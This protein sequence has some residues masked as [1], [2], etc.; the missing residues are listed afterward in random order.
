MDAHELD[1]VANML[2][3]GAFDTASY[4]SHFTDTHGQPPTI[5]SK[6]HHLRSAVQAAV[7]HSGRYT[8]DPNYAEF[9]RVQIFDD[10][11]KKTLLLRSIGAVSI[12]R[13]K[14]Q[15]E[16]LFDSTKYLRSDVVLL[17]FEF[18]RTWLDLHV[19]GTRQQVGRRRLEASG[20]PTHVGRWFMDS[21][22]DGGS[23]DQGADEFFGDLGEGWDEG[24]TGES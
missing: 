21:G 4:S 14:R 15:S 1:P 3:E 17:A 11:T 20:V 9:G 22:D 13:N 2:I 7:N 8:L 24:E 23:F 5:A 10:V 19:A 18:G 6:V 16:T 12:E